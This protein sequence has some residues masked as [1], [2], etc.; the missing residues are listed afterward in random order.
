MKTWG[1]IDEENQEKIVGENKENALPY[2]GG[3]MVQ[4]LCK[5]V[6]RFAV[7]Q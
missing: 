1:N 7:M 6:D 2:I 4:K 5:T 3:Y